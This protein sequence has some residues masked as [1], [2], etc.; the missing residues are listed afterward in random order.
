MAEHTPLEPFPDDWERA[1]VIAAHPDDIEWGTAAAVAAWTSA[2]KQVDYLLV[3]RG[4]AGIEGLPPAEAGPAREEEECRSAAIVGVGDVEFLGHADGRIEEGLALRRD[5]AGVIRRRRPD[6]VV[7]LHHGERWGDSPGAGWNVADHRATGR[8]ALDAVA[9]AGN[10]WIFPELAEA[11]L[12]RW[13]GVV[14]KA[15][16]ASA[17]PTHTVDVTDH[18]DA[19]VA[20]LAAHAR[21]IE[22]LQD[23]PPEDFA[24]RLVE[25]MT[26]GATEGFGGRRAVTFELIGG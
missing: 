22:A 23:D 20:S 19:A 12:E 10:D 6:V 21:Y 24:R 11:G 1:L 7:S 3:T 8:S 4:E 15:V 17:T 16:A 25:Q 5:L 26:A 18:L 2:G 13:D 14:H 9:D